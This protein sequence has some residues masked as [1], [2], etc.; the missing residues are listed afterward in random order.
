M[1][2]GEGA[3]AEAEIE[4]LTSI[5]EVEKLRVGAA[6][7]DRE[8]VVGSRREGGGGRGRRGDIRV[9]GSLR[10][11]ASSNLGGV[12]NLGVGQQEVM[13]KGRRGGERGQDGQGKNGEGQR[14]PK[15]RW[16]LVKQ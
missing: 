1:G 14:G 6:G 4:T 13:G 11:K 2:G 12:E 10:W 15:G 5:Y 16:V 9:G 8:G 3:E 7:G